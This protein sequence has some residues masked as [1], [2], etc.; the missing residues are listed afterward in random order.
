[1]YIV[2]KCW[3]LP[4]V[5]PITIKGIQLSPEDGKISAGKSASLTVDVTGTI[6][7]SI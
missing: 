4:T 7:R 2:F 3:F 1:M 6:R 5:E